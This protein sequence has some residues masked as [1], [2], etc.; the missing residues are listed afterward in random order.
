VFEP[1]LDARDLKLARAMS[2]CHLT[3]TQS[4]LGRQVN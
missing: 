3:E 2:V 4:H 1:F